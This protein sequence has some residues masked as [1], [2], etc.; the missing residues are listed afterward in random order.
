MVQ[1]EGTPVVNSI[2][3]QDADCVYWKGWAGATAQCMLQECEK[4]EH[5]PRKFKTLLSILLANNTQQ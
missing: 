4:L 3:F 1:A 2:H 5:A